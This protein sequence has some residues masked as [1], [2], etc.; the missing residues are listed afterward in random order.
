MSRVAD[1]SDITREVI[2]AHALTGKICFPDACCIIVAYFL[3][4]FW[5]MKVIDTEVENCSMLK[6]V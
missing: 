4:F 5:I 3:P 2:A 6:F 1:F